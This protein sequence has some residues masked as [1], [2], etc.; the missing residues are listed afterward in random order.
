METIAIRLVNRR[1]QE[2]DS[3]TR[4][5]ILSSLGAALF[6]AA[7]LLRQFGVNRGS[8]FQLMLAAIVLWAAITAYRFRS[9]IWPKPAPPGTF[10]A[11]GLAHYRAVLERRRA[12]MKSAWIWHGPLILACLILLAAAVQLAFPNTERLKNILP[13]S[14]LLI[15]WIIFG[16]Y[17][18]Q[19]KAAEI[20]REINEL[21]SSQP[22]G[23]V[24]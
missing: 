1:V 22:T 13:F 5:E 20:Q 17:M 14:T 15:V 6:C 3:A 19:R 4:M 24:T 10:A 12:H 11:T 23:N 7:I 8:L 9:Q 16:I 21:D 2:A 18:R